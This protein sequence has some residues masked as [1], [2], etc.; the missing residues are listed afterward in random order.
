M[1]IPFFKDIIDGVFGTIGGVVSEVVVD[2]DKRNEIN[3]N[4]ERLRLEAL[5]KAEQRT[6]E[7]IM[8]QIEIN[9]TEAQHGSIFVAGWRPFV[10]WVSGVGLAYGVL[11]EPFFSWVARVV[12]GYQGP[13][14][15]I[16]PA[17]LI[18]SL[19]GML[20]IGGMRTY[21]K[22]KGVSSDTIAD[23]PSASRNRPENL[24]PASYNE[25][26]PEDAPWMK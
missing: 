23:N 9:K 2:K 24:L 10:G 21:E 20:G 15:E 7:E 4:L 1:A 3:A 12:I 17:L 18:F 25:E 8:G 26:A 6:H 19:G 16:D 14:P 13:F 5:D 22:V 11:F